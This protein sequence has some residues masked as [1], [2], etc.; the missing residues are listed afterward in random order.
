MAKINI[1]ISSC[2]LG[3]SVRYN[4]G[5][6]LDRYLKETLGDF[7]NY[8]PVCPEVEI[9]LGIPRE[10]MRLVGDPDNPRLLTQKTGIDHTDTMKKWAS[11]KLDSLEKDGL[12]GFIFKSKSPSSGL[13]RVKVYKES[14]VL[15][16]PG[17][18]IFARAFTDRFPL[19]PVEESGRLHDI[20]LRENFLVRVFTLYRW[21]QFLKE[22]PGRG[23]LITFHAQNKYLLMAHNQQILKEMGKLTAQV[24]HLPFN[25]LLND[26]LNL[27]MKALSYQSTVKKN[28]NVLHHILGYFK[29]DLSTWEKSELLERIDEY[30]RQNIPLIAIITMLSHYVKKYEKDYLAGQYYL[31]PHPLELKLRN[32][33]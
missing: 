13:H 22:K 1:G 8:I 10:A 28:V 23:E 33:A 26:Y 7:F 19:I 30:G 14:G 3:N 16:R 18:G 12:C 11:K 27:L 21:Y 29:Q 24:K 15:D 2:I 31:S 32:H 6:T 20:R 17:R 4:G 5:H 9:G 25:E